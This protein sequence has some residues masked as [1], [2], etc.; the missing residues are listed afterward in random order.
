MTPEQCRAARAWLNW[1]QARLTRA[2]GVTVFVVR[3]FEMG[4]REPPA[5]V[6]RELQSALEKS[7]IAFVT[8]SK[9]LGI[10]V[11]RESSASRTE[12]NTEGRAPFGN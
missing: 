7:G 6:R 8:G 12:L 4:R 3:D 10:I 9:S 5:E 11:E 1:S 2:A